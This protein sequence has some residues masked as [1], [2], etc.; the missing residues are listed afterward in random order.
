VFARRLPTGARWRGRNTVGLAMSMN[1][2]WYASLAIAVALLLH[3]APARAAAPVCNG[4]PFLYALPAGLT[5]VEPRAPCTDA[6]GDPIT[7][8]VTVPPHLGTLSPPGALPI[9][10]VRF[11]TAN[12]DAA[13]VANPRDTMTFVATAGGE[14]S[15][16]MRVDVKIL[17]PDHAPVCT[18]AVATV[19]SGH[20]V[21][22]P[23][24]HCVDADGGTP[25]VV[26][27]APAHG[28]YNA[29]TGQY[30]PK[31]GFT[32]KDTMRFA[33]VDYWKVS[34]KI[35]TVTIT[36]TKA[37]GGGGG[38]GGPVPADHKAPRLRL[39]VPTHLDLASTLANGI[40]FTAKTNEDSR[41]AASLYVSRHT[42]H[43][44]G[45]KRHATARV[46]VGRV[47]S[48]LIPGK[49]V[50]AVKLSRKARARLASARRVRL[51]LVAKISDAAGNV[52]TRRVTITLRS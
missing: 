14:Q 18:N 46:R 7:V 41:L 47:V 23:A 34:S 17:P 52:R 27:D 32:G 48:H 3:A 45:I 30:R 50:V 8:D 5:H 43:R 37:A 40:L 36:V 11:Y 22:I 38:G 42:A 25:V 31:A 15:N 26:F 19:A 16:P 35:G 6:D 10:T 44:F 2:V 24:P 21:H 1:R 49:A 20:S 13:S 9:G 29:S 28:T 4:G 12:A 33:A 51:T 39:G